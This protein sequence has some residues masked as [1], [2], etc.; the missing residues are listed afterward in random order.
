MTT[1]I[2]SMYRYEFHWRN[3]DTGQRNDFIVYANHFNTAYEEALKMLP[4]NLAND[5]LYFDGVYIA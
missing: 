5:D 2:N 1:T 3:P 4:D